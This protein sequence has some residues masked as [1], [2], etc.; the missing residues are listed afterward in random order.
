[1]FDYGTSRR[2]RLALRSVF[3]L[4]LSKVSLLQIGY[5][6]WSF[7]MITNRVH[8]EKQP[9]MYNFFPVSGTGFIF[10]FVYFVHFCTKDT[11]GTKMF[12]ERA[13]FKVPLYKLHFFILRNWYVEYKSL[14]KIYIYMLNNMMML[15][16]NTHNT[17]FHGIYGQTSIIS[18]TLVRNTIVDHSDVVG[19]APTFST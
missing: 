4:W 8:V 7:I 6:C 9:F 5:P 17:A 11:T 16:N 19:G 3:Y 14:L 1:M 12:V 2:C 13:C 18:H 10:G 15:W